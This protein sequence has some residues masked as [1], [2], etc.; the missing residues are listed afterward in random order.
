M[1][2]PSQASATL[3]TLLRLREQLQLVRRGKE[4][5]EMKRDQLIREIYR[6]LDEIKRRSELDEEFTALYSR[7]KEAYMVRGPDEISSYSRAVSKPSFRVLYESLMGVRIPHI[8]I[9]K[10][11]DLD[12]ITDPALRE[13]AKEL[14]ELMKKT[15]A[16]GSKEMA[17]ENLS[18][19]LAYIN[20]VVNSLE[21]NI[22]P[23]L[24]ENIRYIEVRIQ[25]ITLSE[26]VRIK[27]IRDL[28][29]KRRGI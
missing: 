12:K 27:K 2:L 23:Q 25:E 6:L 19:E 4:I 13:L 26:F 24:Q 29:H 18:H 20:R 11:P 7:M 14:W 1:S 9:L 28:L 21:K 16:I 17:V 15:I 3:G 22:I 5:L 8:D 10:E